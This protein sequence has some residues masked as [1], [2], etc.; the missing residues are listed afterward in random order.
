VTYWTDG[1]PLTGLTIL[2]HSGSQKTYWYEIVGE[3]RNEGASQIRYAET[4]ATLYDTAGKVARCDFGYVEGTH[5]EAGQTS[6]FTLNVSV[7]SHL[8]VSSYRLQ[9]DGQR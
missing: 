3:A 8:P 2:N 9:T 5:L 1:T 6:S 4:I 7:Y